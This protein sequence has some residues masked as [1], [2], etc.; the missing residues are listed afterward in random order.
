MQRSIQNEHKDVLHSPTLWITACD[1]DNALNKSKTH[2][3]L[4]SR[5][6]NNF[7]ENLGENNSLIC[8][9]CIT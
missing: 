5:T 7:P 9:F 3:T 1:V 8:I 2:N 4:N 6:E